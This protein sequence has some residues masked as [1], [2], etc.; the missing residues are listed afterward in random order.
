M[1]KLFLA[2][3]ELI[4]LQNRY[5]AGGEGHGHFKI[6][7]AEVM[8]E[9]F[10]PYTQKREYYMAHQDEVREILNSGAQKARATASEM[11]YKIRD[12]TGITY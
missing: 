4:E 10:K 11:I 5:K 12:V 3:N 1:A 6:Y 2:E 8:R 7:L 9:Y